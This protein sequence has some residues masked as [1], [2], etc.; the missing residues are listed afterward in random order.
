MEREEA[1]E[2]L[3]EK[4]RDGQ[5]ILVAGLENPQVP[6]IHNFCPEKY[7]PSIRHLGFG[8]FEGKTEHG[9]F[10]FDAGGAMREYRGKGWWIAW[11]P[12]RA[13]KAVLEDLG[14]SHEKVEEGLRNEKERSQHN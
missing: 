10:S 9:E 12:L 6:T 13:E 5:A 1:I 14:Y 11:T 8:F 4:V 2:E 3:I 7:R